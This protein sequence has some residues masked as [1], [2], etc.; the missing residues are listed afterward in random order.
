MLKDNLNAEV[1]LGTVSNVKE[2]CNW[3]GYSYLYVRMQANP[4]VYGLTWE[5]V[6]QVLSHLTLS[7]TGHILIDVFYPF[8][9]HFFQ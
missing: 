3:L 1:V 2:A 7:Y 6:S 5:D 4:L 8:F 9:P